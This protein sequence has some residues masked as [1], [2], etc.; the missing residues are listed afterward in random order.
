[1]YDTCSPSIDAFV[2]PDGF[3]RRAFAKFYELRDI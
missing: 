1:M 3:A 2:N